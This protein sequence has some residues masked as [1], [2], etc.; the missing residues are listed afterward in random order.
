M[1]YSTESYWVNIVEVLGQCRRSWVDDLSYK[2][3]KSIERHTL[4]MLLNVCVHNG[5]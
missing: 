1:L 2:V 3:A 5:L 4:G